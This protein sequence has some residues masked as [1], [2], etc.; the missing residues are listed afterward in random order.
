[1][2]LDDDLIAIKGIG[3]KKYKLLNNLNL[4][5][6]KDLLTNFPRTYVDRSKV[7]N[8]NE[9]ENESI[10]T[11]KLLIY[12]VSETK[13]AYKKS[14]LRLKCKDTNGYNVAIIFFNA[15]FLL[16][17]FSIGKEY[18]FYGKIVKT[19]YEAKMFH[20]EFSDSM[21]NDKKFLRIEPIYSLTAGITNKEMINIYENI[22]DNVLFEENLFSPYIIQNKLC[23]INYAFK[24][25]NLPT[26]K[27]ALKKAR[28][29]FIY[30]EFFNLFLSLSLIKNKVKSSGGIVLKDLPMVDFYKN[31]KFTLTKSQEKVWNQIKI[32][33]TSN[34]QMNRLL[35]GDVGSGKTIVAM[36]AMYLTYKNNMQSTLM[37][38]TSVLA[39]Q[40]FR[41]FSDV[42]KNF[43]IKIILL[44]GNTKNKKQ[45]YKDI[46]LGKYDIIIG[47]HAILEE[48]VKFKNL[49][50]VITDEQHRFGVKQRNILSTKEKN[51]NV[52]V[53]SATPIPR[54]LSLIIYGDVDISVIDQLP[55]GRKQIK[56]HYVKKNKIND[57]Y[58]F[59]RSKVEEKRQIYFICPLIEE[60][61]ALDIK[62]ASELYKELSERIYTKFNVKLL[63]GK[64]KAKEKETIMKDF[65]EG[66]INILISTTVIEVGINVPNA[67]IMVINDANRFG[68]SQLH[69]LRG[70]VG[71][72][73]YQSY[74]FMTSNKMGDTSKKRI[75]TMIDTNDGFEI[76]ERDLLLRGPG[77]ILGLK[78]HGLPELKIGE[79]AKHSQ[80]FEIVKM[81]VNNL[82]Q[83]YNQGE[84]ASV[85]FIIKFIENRLSNN[86]NI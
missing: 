71:R 28:Y 25:I 21:Y 79:L 70:R 40:H 1:M 42:L 77:E 14:T 61:E 41:T 84:K 36:M 35:Q 5:K 18:Y 3:K 33:L 29:R 66:K 49:A 37:V 9:I 55:S 46:E 72:G 67:S 54:T 47:T 83:M 78:Q 6:V 63:H 43:N 51:V 12:D 2:N 59:I 85:E 57:M 76:A 31:L 60:S 4:Y 13:N 52:L 50:L 10:S 44:T 53:M 75:Q 24:N 58:E 80:I 39:N 16:K 34:N 86:I 65:S 19:H 7:N 68:L 82:V 73:E 64:M 81:D 23:D 11:I 38:P 22:I 69:Q 17:K 8:I 45:I 15:S 27:E 30:E 62:S 32:D 48:G 20:P 26:S 74:C 56:T